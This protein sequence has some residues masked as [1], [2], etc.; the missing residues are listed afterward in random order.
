MGAL[1]ST[2]NNAIMLISAVAIQTMVILIA[3]G[4]AN[5]AKDGLNLQWLLRFM[6]RCMDC[7]KLL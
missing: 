4:V 1:L 7:G 3:G 2:V 5:V 6:R